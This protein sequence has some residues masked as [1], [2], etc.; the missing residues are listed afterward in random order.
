MPSARVILRVAIPSPL[1]RL[2]DYLTPAGTAGSG[3]VPG[4]R[5][6]VPFGRSEAIGVVLEIVPHTAIDEARLKQVHEVLDPQPLLPAEIVELACWVSR[7]YHHPI[8]EVLS[9]TLPAVLR[10]GAPAQP[11]GE[12]VWRLTESGRALEASALARAPRQAAILALLQGAPDGV[13]RNELERQAG[14]WRR[15]LRAMIQQGW[16]TRGNALADPG[17]PIQASEPRAG[18]TLNR[19]QREAVAAVSGAMS[20]FEAFLLFGVTGSGKTEV[21]LQIVARI[22]AEGRQALVLVPEI[23]L[24]PQLLERFRGRFRETLAVFHSGLSDTER[25]NAWLAAREGR[26]RIVIGTR[27][28]VFT[29][30]ARPGVVIVDEEHDLSYKQQEGLRYSARDLAVVR[31]RQ[32]GVPVVLAS[33][34][35]SLES[36]HNAQTGRYRLL[37]LPERAGSALQPRM[38]LLDVRGKPM[39]DGLSDPLSARIREHLD[40]QGQV[41]LFLNRRGYAPT[42]LCHQ[43]GWVCGCQRCDAHMTLHYRHR[44]LRCHHCGA[45]QAVEAACPACG[46]VDLRAVGQG[47]ERMELALAQ[48]FPEAKVVR[49]DRDTTRR[50][51]DMQSKL[52]AVLRG[53]NRILVGTQMLAKGHHFPDVTLVAIVDA[54]QG[55]FSADFRAP[56]RMAQLVLQVAGRAGRAERP[57]EVIVQTHHPDHPLLRLLSEQNYERFAEAALAERREAA[58]PP[59]SSLALLRAEAPAAQAPRA[60]LQEALERARSHP[61]REVDFFGPVAAPMERRQGRFRAQVLIQAASR[62]ALRALLGPWVEELATLSSAR[63]VRWSL[64]VDPMDML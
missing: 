48:R 17:D 27:S 35:P 63:R 16:V 13:R 30:L 51:G 52:E 44:R 11:R 15:A 40:R 25:L 9:A 55:L 45:E 26:A 43:C 61:G 36:L 5:V 28:A 22:L 19:P 38:E 53:E 49:I 58:L 8:G 41:L 33:A 24:T 23:A 39:E 4:V 54:D 6:R 7:Y 56:E 57:G 1:Y 29:P 62:G 59:F 14:D 32:G 3:A 12:P 34:T 60:F 64:D 37:R 10:R 18:P 46:S 2:F 47:T 31:A 20:D 50:K 21:Y 42:L